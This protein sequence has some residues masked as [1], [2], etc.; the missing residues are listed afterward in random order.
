MY[1]KKIVEKVEDFFKKN[2]LSIIMGIFHK[3]VDSAK[4][5]TQKD[6]KKGKNREQ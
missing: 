2:P 1:K 6:V 5:M 3:S 4:N